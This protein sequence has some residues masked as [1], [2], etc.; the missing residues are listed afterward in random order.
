MVLFVM[1]QTL[2]RVGGSTCQGLGPCASSQT[3]TGQ[4]GTG[5]AWCGGLLRGMEKGLARVSVFPGATHAWSVTVLSVSE[6]DG[7]LRDALPSK[8]QSTPGYA[9]RQSRSHGLL[10]ASSRKVT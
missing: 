9:K 7:F 5:L 3:D 2:K 4:T 6:E 10:Q 1:F 8:L